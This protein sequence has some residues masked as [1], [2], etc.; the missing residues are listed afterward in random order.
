MPF[1]TGIGF[2]VRNDKSNARRY[3]CG[4]SGVISFSIGSR[5]RNTRNDKMYAFYITNTII[6]NGPCKVDRSASLAFC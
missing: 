5:T 6:D 3:I 2:V 1:V 4:C